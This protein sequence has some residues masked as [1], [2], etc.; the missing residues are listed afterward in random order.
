MSTPCAASTSAGLADVAQP[1]ADRCYSVGCP[2]VLTPDTSVSRIDRDRIR[3]MEVDAVIIIDID[4][5]NK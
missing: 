1:A 2:H 5:K 4:A 3:E